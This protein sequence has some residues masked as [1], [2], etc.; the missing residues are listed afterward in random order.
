MTSKRPLNIGITCYPTYGGSG[1]IATELGMA[2]AARGHRVH[3]IAYDI[4]RRLNQFLDNV[5]FH[6]VE[7]R[8]NPVFRHPPYTLA[9]C[10]KM[11]DVATNEKID[12]FHVHYAVPHATSAY[13]AKQILGARAPKI[14]TT[15]HGTDITLVGHDRSYL[16]ITRFSIEQS[17][18]VTA[19]SQFLKDAT[20]QKLGVSSDRSILIVPNFVDTEEFRPFCK[21]NPC[22]PRP[23]LSECS[24]NEKVLIH[25]SNFRPV[26]Q[27]DQV[28][29]VFNLVQ[30]QVPCHLILVGDGPE[31]STVEALVKELGLKNKV[32]FFGKQD[33]IAEIL[34]RSHVFLLP[35]K[36]ESFG[37]AA[38]EAM[39]CGVP[40]VASR[41]EGIP[42]VVLHGKVGYLAEP[43]NV[44]EMAAHTLSLLKDEALYSRMSLSARELVVSQYGKDLLATQ[45][46]SLYYSLTSASR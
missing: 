16:P 8:D 43:D 46:E 4:P 45:F 3:F 25:V 17:D 40:V 30:K 41:V 10:S 29:K 28:V 18:E 11:V 1:V 33:S 19:P 26:K 20:Y 39:S 21:E 37:L 42:E 14:L 2:M 38:L 15:L 7:L 12:L 22:K 34:Q 35:S 24:T 36:N 6:E 44:E 27:V 32:C 5:F 23:K 13:L 31:R 9:L